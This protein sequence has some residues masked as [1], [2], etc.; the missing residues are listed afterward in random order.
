L[1]GVHSHP[2]R[3]LDE[4]RAFGFR[5]VIG[6]LHFGNMPQSTGASSDAIHGERCDP[7]IS[8]RANAPLPSEDSKEDLN[9]VSQFSDA[10]A[11]IW[12]ISF[13]LDL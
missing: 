7:T 5:K 6:W 9:S 10:F 11:R 3:Q 1:Y 2:A 13:S 8:S 4:F 12:R